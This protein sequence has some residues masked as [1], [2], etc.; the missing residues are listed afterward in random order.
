MLKDKIDTAR[1]LSR[2]DWLMLVQAWWLLLAV[3]LGLRALP[4][5]RLQTWAA[6][7][8]RRGESSAP[9]RT[10]ATIQR[11]RRM[12]RI[13]S[14]NHL[15][16]MTCLRR[17]LV[18]QRLLSRRGIATELRFGVQKQAGKLQAHA[19]LEHAGRPVGEP[20]ALTQRYALLAVQQA[21]T[22]E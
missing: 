1:K 16:A 18:M 12:V 22:H 4:F 15:Y 2:A 14:R 9:A 21:P 8:A 11:A 6:R 3:D 5:P 20:E 10:E 13:A 19:W 7:T 17:S